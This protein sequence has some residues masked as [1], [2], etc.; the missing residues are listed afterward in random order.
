MKHE[1]LFMVLAAA[2][3]T[4]CGANEP[5][6]QNALDVDP[7]VEEAVENGEP[8]V[9]VRGVTNPGTSALTQDEI[10]LLN[11]LG[12]GLGDDPSAYDFGLGEVIVTPANTGIPIVL[13]AV[14][15]QL[16]SDDRFWDNTLLYAWAGL[17]VSAG[18]ADYL[19]QFRAAG[20][21]EPAVQPLDPLSNLMLPTWIIY[22]DAVADTTYYNEDGTLTLDI[23][24]LDP[25]TEVDC[26]AF[27]FFKDARCTTG[28]IEG[29][30]DMS[31]LGYPG[32]GASYRAP[33]DRGTS[34][35]TLDLTATIDV[36]VR[37]A[38]IA[39]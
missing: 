34:T 4:A 22:S 36:P 27:L 9:Q 32:F 23:V 16:Q 30:I 10:D 37:R 17:D 25:A 3:S 15:I 8:P 18:T 14:A 29:E 11:D 38:S 31:T 2:F 33:D 21:T 20:I 24:D 5:T 1:N 39:R 28:T 6:L 12:L 35:S 7:D 26:T 19:L 13:D